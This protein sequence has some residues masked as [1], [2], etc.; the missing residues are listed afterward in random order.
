MDEQL[1]KELKEIKDSIEK[2][3]AR[4]NG[5]GSDMAGNFTTL[6][7]KINKAISEVEKEIIDEIVKFKK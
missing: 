4:I 3:Q 1:K 6:N 5:L 7:S 2:L